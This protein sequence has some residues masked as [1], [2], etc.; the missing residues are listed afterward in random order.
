MN[1]KHLDHLNLSVRNFKETADWYGRVF[2][3]EVVESGLWKGR[4]WGVLKAGDAMLCAYED[5]ERKFVDGDGLKAS[6]QH[7]LNH[8][9]LRISDREI[10]QRTIE[11]ENVQVEYGGPVAWPHSRSW[12]VCDPTG[13]EIE[14]VAW[15]SDEVRFS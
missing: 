3:F 2:G 8:F 4:P 15:N 14:V 7:G 13:Y 1:V 5:A 6:H 10:W 11:R 9:A 12:Y